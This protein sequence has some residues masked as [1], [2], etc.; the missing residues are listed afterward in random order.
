MRDGKKA[1]ALIGCGGMGS[2]HAFALGGK[3]G[4]TGDDGYSSYNVGQEALINLQDK[5]VLTGVYDI[6]PVR[7]DWAK[8]NGF[9]T[10]DSYQDM[11]NDSTVD[12]ILIATPNHLH[13]DMALA[14]IT[15]GKHVLCEKP[16]MM[17]AAEL[18]E[19][20]AAAKTAGKVFYP[21]QN[22]R[23]D[24]DYLILKKLY[25]ENTVGNAFCIESR[26]TGSRGIPCD[27]RA[28]KQYGGGMMLDWGV[29]L[30]DRLL[31][32]IPGYVKTVFCQMT[33]V[34]NGEVDDGFQMHLTFESGLTAIVEV[35]TCHF[36][37][38]P[39]WYLAGVNGSVQINNWDCTGEIAVLTSWEE[40][41]AKPILA[42][43]GLTKT[44]APRSENSIQKHS[45]PNLRVDR[46]GLYI[47]LVDVIDGKSEQ[48][49]TGEQALR[50]L[51][52]M[53][54]AIESDATKSVVAFE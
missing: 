3:G 31:W 13:K 23:W 19:V 6:N 45:L 43:E 46:D 41:D 10:Y 22:R 39:L 18:I 2:G 25:E 30:I 37:A 54:A 7:M 28:E 1:I 17:N 49:V 50:V 16:V 9:G 20:I 14:A 8:A 42:G 26:V 51:R 52:L 34:N 33:H 4:Y 53:E 44:M 35:G 5:L 21:R 40:K 15:A 29:H 11:L 27:W 48:I 32:M 12:I 36:I 24:K 38:K 47:N